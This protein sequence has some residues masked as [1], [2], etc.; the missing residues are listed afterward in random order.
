MWYCWIT[1]L[2]KNGKVLFFPTK[3]YLTSNCSKP[4]KVFTRMKISGPNNCQPT[5]FLLLDFLIYQNYIPGSRRIFLNWVFVRRT[6][7]FKL[8]TTSI[9]IRVLTFAKSSCS[10]NR[11]I[12]SYSLSDF[13]LIWSNCFGFIHS[14]LPLL[15]PRGGCQERGVVVG[16]TR[17]RCIRLQHRT[18]TTS[19]RHFASHD[20]GAHSFSTERARLSGGTSLCS[21]FQKKCLLPGEI[22]FF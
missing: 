17:L 16:W 13:Q 1:D 15:P 4:M 12:I 7:K 3:K 6:Q 21:W 20:L 9:P 11:I 18:C 2:E 5:S 14:S 10:D 8:H 22:F 19:Q